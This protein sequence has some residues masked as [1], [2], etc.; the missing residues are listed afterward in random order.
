M[1]M[2]RF[3]GDKGQPA[4]R[5]AVPGCKGMTKARTPDKHCQRHARQQIEQGVVG[6]GPVDKV[7]KSMY[8][9][10]VQRRLGPLPRLTLREGINLQDVQDV[11]QELEG[12]LEKLPA[13]RRFSDLGRVDAKT[14]VQQ[15]LRWI[16]DQRGVKQAA[17]LILA[18]ALGVRLMPK[19][20]SGA[21]YQTAQ[22]ARSV[23][24][25]LRSVW[26]IDYRRQRVRSKLYV[27]GVQVQREMFR[28]VE[29]V[30]RT[31]VWTFQRSIEKELAE[32][33]KA[34][35]LELA[36]VVPQ[37]QSRQRVEA[38]SIEPEAETREPGPV[39]DCP[40]CREHSWR[41]ACQFHYNAE[42]EGV[43]RG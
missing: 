4:K 5:C 36:G 11:L 25:L 43:V 33:S 14:K 22:V 8:V 42:L 18:H 30:Y 32:R 39:A 24:Q 10:A 9:Q 26:I 17:R 16:S 41:D 23:L 13:A 3:R 31:L 21:R 27:Q 15:A 6:V 34:R 28:W 38:E 35:R 29:P 2:R 19:L 12:K 1:R 37:K 40:S 20:N 7:L